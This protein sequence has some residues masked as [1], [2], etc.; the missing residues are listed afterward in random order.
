MPFAYTQ[1]AESFGFIGGAMGTRPSLEGKAGEVYKEYMDMRDQSKMLELM[2]KYNEG[3]KT[4]EPFD[5]NAKDNLADC[6]LSVSTAFRKW[7]NSSAYKKEDEKLYQNLLILQGIH[8]ADGQYF[9]DELNFVTPELGE[10]TTIS[11]NGTTDAKTLKDNAKDFSDKVKT[12]LKESKNDIKDYNE[13]TGVKSHADTIKSEGVVLSAEKGVARAFREA[14]PNQLAMQIYDRVIALETDPSQLTGAAKTQYDQ[15]MSQYPNF[16][17]SHATHAAVLQAMMELTKTKSLGE[18][19]DKLGTTSP[20]LSSGFSQRYQDITNEFFS[21]KRPMLKAQK[22]LLDRRLAVK[23]ESSNLTNDQDVKKNA[24]GSYTV[25][26]NQHDNGVDVATKFL[27]DPKNAALVKPAVIRI[28]GGKPTRVVLGMQE[29]LYAAGAPPVVFKNKE[30]KRLEHGPSGTSNYLNV[31]AKVQWDVSKKQ[32]GGLPNKTKEMIGEELLLLQALCQKSNKTSSET[33]ETKGLGKLWSKFK[34][35]G[36]NR[37]MSQHKL[38]NLWV[39]NQSLSTLRKTPLDKV[40]LKT[41]KILQKAIQKRGISNRSLFRK[42]DNLEPAQRNGM[43]VLRFKQPELFINQGKG[44]MGAKSNSKS[45]S[46]KGGPPKVQKTFFGIAKV[47]TG[48]LGKVIPPLG[49]LMHKDAQRALGLEDSEVQ[50]QM[51]EDANEQLM[52]LEDLMGMDEKGQPLTGQALFDK[53]KALLIQYTGESEIKGYSNQQVQEKAAE[54]CRDLTLNLITMAPDHEKFYDTYLKDG[55]QNINPGMHQALKGEMQRIMVDLGDGSSQDM[56]QASDDKQNVAD[57]RTVAEIQIR[58]TEKALFGKVKSPKW[59][60]SKIKG[61][62]TLRLRSKGGRVQF[63]ASP[64]PEDGYLPYTNGGPNVVPPVSLAGVS[65][66]PFGEGEV[67]PHPMLASGPLGNVNPPLGESK[68][69]AGPESVRSYSFDEGALFKPSLERNSIFGQEGGFSGLG[70][71]NGAHYPDSSEA[72]MLRLRDNIGV[73]E[74]VIEE[75]TSAGGMNP[76]EHFRAKIDILRSYNVF[77]S[78]VQYGDPLRDAG[79]RSINDLDPKNEEHVD[80]VQEKVGLLIANLQGANEGL[81]AELSELEAAV[82]QHHSDEITSIENG[83]RKIEMTLKR[84]EEGSSEEEKFYNREVLLRDRGWLDGVNV[85]KLDFTNPTHKALVDVKVAE[86]KEKMVAR[87]ESFK[88]ALADPDEDLP[89][90]SDDGDSPPSFDSTMLSEDS[91]D[92]EKVSTP[93]V[94]REGA[95]FDLKEDISTLQNEISE[96]QAVIAKL[97]RQV[98]SGSPDASKRFNEQIDILQSLGLLTDDWVEN[99]QSTQAQSIGDLDPT[100]SADRELV[101]EKVGEL[102]N[103]L[104]LKNAAK[105]VVLDNHQAQLENMNAGPDVAFDKQ[106][107][108][109]LM[110]EMLNNTVLNSEKTEPNGLKAN[111]RSDSFKSSEVLGRSDASHMPDPHMDHGSDQDDAY[112]DAE[113]NSPSTPGP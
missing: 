65:P 19:N 106:E 18:V 27:K 85:G 33:K 55:N 63:P 54:V 89:N 24:D 78:P 59:V 41:R 96:N 38:L 105:E 107:V 32:G 56:F 53:Q 8:G 22:S 7:Q 16:S 101:K 4:P 40:D 81:Q 91:F 112:A 83:L 12:F 76:G 71:S 43:N 29:T 52:L 100:N 30:G 102:I 47:I 14:S 11:T 23:K 20:V 97:N 88:Q 51:A 42:A 66:Y 26:G 84:L 82:A 6:P 10:I 5:V 68:S 57:L 67:G 104:K 48:G 45:I 31:L 77:N 73:N 103:H 13:S 61:K 95:I 90:M 98:N 62:E 2:G 50:K 3:K 21:K 86:M 28:Q 17:K 46:D 80:V 69:H 108:E 64:R 75:L 113:H 9:Q 92:E 72:N 35:W 109:G 110:G 93:Q 94:D 39:K 37:P 111:A 74:D 44:F 1:A 79:V 15:S 87:S 34:D 25:T 36:K 70:V 99:D 58:N 60:G 49:V